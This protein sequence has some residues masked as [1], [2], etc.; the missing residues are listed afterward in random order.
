E[1][2]EVGGLDC[3]RDRPLDLEGG[4]PPLV[5]LRA[6][7]VRG[8]A[9]GAR[10]REDVREAVAAREARG[11]IRRRPGR[12]RGRRGV[13]RVRLGGEEERAEREENHAE[14][15]DAAA[16]PRFV[17]ARPPWMSSVPGR[18]DDRAT[19]DAALAASV[20]TLVR[21]SPRT[22]APRIDG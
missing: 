14:A 18:R 15:R 3:A 22:S 1:A 7:R 13:R 6:E 2:P 10:V 21:A 16:R 20:E 9:L 4:G 11:G 12:R 8:S 19:G 17:H 5:L